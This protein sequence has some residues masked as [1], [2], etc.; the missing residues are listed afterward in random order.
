MRN[1]KNRQSLKAGWGGGFSERSHYALLY[2]WSTPLIGRYNCEDKYE[3]WKKPT[4][5]DRIPL[6]SSSTHSLSRLA[7]H[8]KA[9]ARRSIIAVSDVRESPS[10]RKV[11]WRTR[12]GQNGT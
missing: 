4:V 10:W 12:Y 7:R 9:T 6:T 2:P 8:Q 11:F 5:L 3:A 1:G